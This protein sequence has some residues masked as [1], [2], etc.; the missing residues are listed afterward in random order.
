MACRFPNEIDYQIPQEWTRKVEKLPPKVDVL[1]GSSRAKSVETQLAK[2]HP[3]P[4]NLIIHAKSSA[5]LYDL[6][7][8]AI[9]II[10]SKH[11][12][13]YTTDVKVYFL[14]GYCDLTE[15]LMGANYEEVVFLEDVEHAVQRVIYN[16]DQASS[17]ITSFNFSPVFSTIPPGNLDI[18]NNTRFLQRKTNFL[19]YSS[20]YQEMNKNII[21]AIVQIN[22]HILAKNIQNSVST[23]YVASTIM[24]NHPGF[25]RHGNRY[26]PRVH[27][28]RLVDGVHPTEKLSNNWARALLKAM[29]KNRGL[30][31]HKPQQSP[32]CLNPNL[33]NDSFDLQ[34]IKIQENMRDDAI[35]AALH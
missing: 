11:L 18:W 32:G 17:Y 25:D 27:Y 13:P 6:S 21:Q 2:T 33:L 19:N 14:A 34:N 35:R 9:N 20:R 24:D 10:Q 8:K 23:P 30:L 1:V 29:K 28:S 5:K 7:G 4:S 26:P 3:D 22:K 16:I 31:P 15:M 12:D